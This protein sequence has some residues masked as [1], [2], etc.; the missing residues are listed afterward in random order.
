MKW[1][2]SLL[3]VIGEKT[4]REQSGYSSLVERRWRV[5]GTLWSRI[6]TTTVVT[7]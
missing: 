7:R 5:N 6:L 4:D 3:N 2:R 1:I